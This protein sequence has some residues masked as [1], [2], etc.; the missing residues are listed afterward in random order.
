ML[1]RLKGER[2]PSS[3]LGKTNTSKLMELAGSYS[4]STFV[5]LGVRFGYSSEAFLAGGSARGNMVH[6]VDIDLSRIP[7]AVHGHPL[8]ESTRGD[9]ATV[10]RYW[11]PL[12]SVSILFVDTIHVKEMILA[13]LL[14]WFSS[15]EVGGTFVFHDT[16]WEAGMHETI[17]GRDW[18]RPEAAVVEFFGLPAHTDMEDDFVSVR[19]MPESYGMT[20][21]TLKKRHNFAENV[22]DW[23]SVL[24]RR[25]EIVELYSSP[26]EVTQLGIDMLTGIDPVAFASARVA[27]A[28]ARQDRI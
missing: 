5:D 15:V 18:E 3:D 21:V 28:R 25:R 23:P 7:Q 9:S 27:A 11:N 13:E 8:Y 26:Q 4:N 16:H 6:G 20:F 2:R 1:N 24:D 17:N 14:T 22:S 19:C 12:R 10:G